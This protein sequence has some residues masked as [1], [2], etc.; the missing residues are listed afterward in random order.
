MRRWD[1]VCGDARRSLR[2]KDNPAPR[3]NRRSKKANEV[4]NLKEVAPIS[5]ENGC[6]Q[7]GWYPEA[8]ATRSACDRV[9]KACEGWVALLSVTQPPRWARNLGGAESHGG[10]RQGSWLNPKTRVRDPRDEQSPGATMWRSRHIQSREGHGARESVRRSGGR[11]AS[12]GEPHERNRDETSSEGR[13]G[14]KASK[15]SETPRTQRNP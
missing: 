7:H 9:D 1:A 14:S 10:I 2:G 4:G 13:E 6:V 15:G 12:K 5:R 11:K 3:S 8:P